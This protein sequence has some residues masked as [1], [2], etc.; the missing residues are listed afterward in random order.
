MKPRREGLVFCLVTLVWMLAWCGDIVQAWRH[1]PYDRLGWVAA[2][3]WAAWVVLA[4]RR[5]THASWVWWAAAWL[6]SFVGVAG[7]LNVVQHAALALAAAAWVG[8]GGRGWGVLVLA[9][10]W[11]P[12]LGWV[13]RGAGAELV[14]GVRLLAGTAGLVLAW[15]ERRKM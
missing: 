5:V 8:G 1:S 11:L 15:R 9:A 13:G 10:G 14:L 7:E 4:G 12:A 3:G 6:V 2:G